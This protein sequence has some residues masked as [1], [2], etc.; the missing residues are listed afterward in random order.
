MSLG[1]EWLSI[2]LV[3][4]ELALLVD[5]L[6]EKIKYEISQILDT[7]LFQKLQWD[8][9]IIHQKIFLQKMVKPQK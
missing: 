1:V 8:Q 3:Y 6:D 4:K 9:M 5:E 7:N 2:E